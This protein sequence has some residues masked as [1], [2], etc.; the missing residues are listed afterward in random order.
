MRILIRLL[1][2]GLIGLAASLGLWQ[3]QSLLPSKVA[4]QEPLPPLTTLTPTPRSSFTPTPTTRRGYYNI[5]VVGDFTLPPT[6]SV[7]FCG[8]GRN[9]HAGQDRAKLFRRGFSS[10]DR[11]KM[12]PSE[13][14][15]GREP[16][17]PGWKSPLSFSQRTLWITQNY[18]SSEPFRLEWAANSAKADETIFRLPDSLPN[19]RQTLYRASFELSGSCYFF[20]DCPPDRMVNTYSKVFLDIENEYISYAKRQ[21]QVNLYVYMM[22]ILKEHVDPRTEIG[23]ITPVP[24]NGYGYSKSVSYKALADWLWATPARHTATS[25]SRGMPDD[26]LGKT[27]EDYADFQMPG[28]YFVYPDLDYNSRHNRDRDRHWLGS[29][30]HEQEVNMRLSARKRIAWQWLFN[31]QS[32][33]F[34]NSEKASFPASPAISEGLAVFYWFTGAYGVLFWDDVTDLTPDSPTPTDP[35]LQ[36]IGNDRNY[37]CYEHYI[38]GLWRLFKHHGDIFNGREQYLNQQTEL[39]FDNGKTWAKYNA[40]QLKLHDGPFVRAIVNGNQILVAATR[41]YA[42]PDQSSQVMI[43]YIRKGYR[44]YSRINLKGD[45]IFLGRATMPAA[46]IVNR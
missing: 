23:S 25:R 15:D 2:L 3:D 22:K 16:K 24:H 40:N 17:P 5:D 12:L 33:Y 29:V 37:T 42:R 18:F 21:E 31:T 41:P 20:N 9:L 11:T 6:K 36:G 27:F 30:L 26:I 32:T 45:E 13:I 7:T 35:A 43:R 46:P 44:F 38:H 8:A 14:N 28:T 1:L 34:P 10:I 4:L 39:S 19:S